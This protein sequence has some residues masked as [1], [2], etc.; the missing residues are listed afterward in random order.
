MF[1]RWFWPVTFVIYGY[2]IW[3]GGFKIAFYIAALGVLIAVYL[4]VMAY[5]WTHGGWMYYRFYRRWW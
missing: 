4:K 3:T 2:I 1:P 5:C